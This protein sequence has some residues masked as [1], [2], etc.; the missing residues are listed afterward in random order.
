MTEESNNTAAGGSGPGHTPD[1]TTSFW[2]SRTRSTQKTWNEYSKENNASNRKATV[3][4]DESESCDAQGTSGHIV[5]CWSAPWPHLLTTPQSF[6]TASVIAKGLSN[7]QELPQQF[8]GKQLG[9]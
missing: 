8:D 1:W 9:Q 7:L 4:P 3:T 2:I 5:Y 6:I